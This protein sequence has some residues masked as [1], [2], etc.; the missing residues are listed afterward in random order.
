MAI[1]PGNLGN[2]GASSG[3]NASQQEGQA[4]PTETPLPGTGGGQAPGPPQAPQGAAQPPQGGSQPQGAPQRP[5]APQGP[6]P[7]D[8]SRGQP[9]PAPWREQLMMWAMHP[10]ANDALRRLAI[11]ANAER[12]G[13]V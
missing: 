8:L 7:L 6:Q 10:H 5:Q 1:D 3:P 9:P 12:A 2:A 4:L 11:L 13:S